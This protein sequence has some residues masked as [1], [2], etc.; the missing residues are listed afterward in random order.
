MSKQEL[1]YVAVEGN[2]YDRVYNKLPRLLEKVDVCSVVNLLTFYCWQ[3]FRISEKW[4]QFFWWH[5]RSRRKE[6]MI[7]MRWKKKFVSWTRNTNSL[8][9]VHPHAVEIAGCRYDFIALQTAT[10][11][12]LDDSEIDSGW[13]KLTIKSPFRPVAWLCP[14]KL[15]TQKEVKTELRITV[16]DKIDGTSGLSGILDILSDFR[17]T[18]LYCLN[19]SGN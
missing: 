16:C 17:I 3:S 10:K 2:V 15:R 12:P 9:F 1:V 19:E 11:L 8:P 18:L 13:R 6:K 5:F 4:V 7:R 14:R